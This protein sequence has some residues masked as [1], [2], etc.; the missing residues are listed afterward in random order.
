MYS[1]NCKTPMKM[2]KVATNRWKD[3]TCSWAGY[4]YYLVTILPKA[5][6]SCATTIQL[7][8][9]RQKAG[10]DEIA[11]ISGSQKK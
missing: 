9:G 3:I 7:P 2:T 10:R 4:Q 8:G 5:I 6:Y 1:Y 11:N